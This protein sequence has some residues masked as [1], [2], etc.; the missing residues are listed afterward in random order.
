METEDRIERMERAGILTERQA[1]QLRASI[2]RRDRPGPREDR[3]RQPVL[4]YLGGALALVLLALLFTTTND[5]GSIQD[6]S[7]TLNDAGA[8]GA[9]NRS[10]LNFIA[11]VLLLVIPIGLLAFAYNS[12]VNREEAVFQNWA[13]VESQFQRRADLVPALIETVSA[14]VAH[15]RETLAEVTANRSRML[16]DAVAS[17]TRKQEQLNSLLMRGDDLLE[18]Q[19]A[20]DELERRQAGLSSRLSGFIALAEDYPELRASDQFLELQAQLEGTENRINVARLQFND[21]VGRYNAAIRRLP[22]TLVAGLGD[23]RRKAYFKADVGA[24]QAPDVDFD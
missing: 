21:A 17:L 12:L 11:I 8:E 7:R 22:G 14:Y 20:M 13:Q 19:S 10:V 16:S 18:E 23:F 2:G 15:E 5:P 24:D 3:R 1:E 6:V 4:L 9:M